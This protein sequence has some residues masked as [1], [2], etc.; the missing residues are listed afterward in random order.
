MSFEDLE[1]KVDS[2]EGG[3]Q[4]NIARLDRQIHVGYLLVYGLY[5][6]IESVHSPNNYCVFT[7]ILLKQIGN[8]YFFIKFYLKFE[9]IRF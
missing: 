2:D 7:K 8:I 9:S 6:A 3:V 4:S 1:I 5:S